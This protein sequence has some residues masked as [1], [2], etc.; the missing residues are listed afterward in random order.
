L[1]I[2]DILSALDL[3]EELVQTL[4][5]NMNG[6]LDMSDAPFRGSAALEAF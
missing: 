2:K 1:I 3:R 4:L 5:F 6:I